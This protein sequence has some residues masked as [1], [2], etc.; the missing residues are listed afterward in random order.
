MASYGIP[1]AL[2]ILIPFTLLV[3][4]SFRK[5]ILK[6]RFFSYE[7][8]FDRSWIISIVLL[9]LMHLVDIQYFDGRISFSGWILLAG[10]RNIIKEDLQ[11]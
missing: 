6:K 5:I 11:I 4:L 2:F 3:G 1:A 8:I 10:I 7:N 9:T